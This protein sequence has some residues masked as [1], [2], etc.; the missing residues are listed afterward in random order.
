MF[1]RSVSSFMKCECDWNKRKRE[2]GSKRERERAKRKKSTKRQTAFFWSKYNLNSENV[3][4]IV[5]FFMMMMMMG[6]NKWVAEGRTRSHSQASYTLWLVLVF[7]MSRHICCF[8]FYCCRW[9]HVRIAI[10]RF[11]CKWFKTVQPC[12]P[13]IYW[14]LCV[15]KE[16]NTRW[17]S[18][19]SCGMH[20][21]AATQLNVDTASLLLAMHRLCNFMLTFVINLILKTQ[22]HHFSC[23]SLYLFCAIFHSHLLSTSFCGC[24]LDDCAASLTANYFWVFCTVILIL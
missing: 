4:E 5:P 17:N 24:R 16:A 12:A 11:F 22:T 13:T 9:F 2:R 7:R 6:E 3:C 20:W 8:V 15:E 19:G 14:C 21:V 23:L 1:D 10:N 18:C